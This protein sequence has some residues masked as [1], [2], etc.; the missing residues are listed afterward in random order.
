MSNIPTLESFFNDLE[1]FTIG[2]APT[3]RQISHLANR[4]SYPPYDIEQVSDTNYKLTLAIA[5]FTDNEIEIT[6]TDRNLKIVGN[7]EQFEERKYIHQGIAG[8]TFVRSF[9]LD[10]DVNVVDVTLENGL[11]Q[12]NLV[13]DV[14]EVKKPK[15]FTVGK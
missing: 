8:R 2:F 14:P 4:T 15:I 10:Q 12:I 11:L 3:V 6:Q 9:Y 7:K 1:R 13:K 5:G